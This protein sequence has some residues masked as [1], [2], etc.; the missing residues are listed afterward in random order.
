[1]TGEIKVN[2]KLKETGKEMKIAILGLGP[3]IK[4]FNTEG[5][6]LSIGVNDIWRYVKSDV[7]VC[8]DH[9]NGFEYDRLNV[10]NES[11]PQKFYSQMVVWDTRPDF[12]KIDFI[13][14][15]PDISC[16]LD[17]V[18]LPKSYCSPFVATVIAY[19]YYFATE[20]HLFG[21]DMVAH[22]HLDR[23]LCEK[24]KIHFQNLKKALKDKNCELVIHGQGILLSI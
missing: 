23:F 5:F 10:I 22:P 3:S 20:V 7:I 16:N 17:M 19:K 1:M 18:A 24:I 13:P 14:G 9:P 15:Y 11:K 21:V 2:R 6:D 8:L 12:I 4:E